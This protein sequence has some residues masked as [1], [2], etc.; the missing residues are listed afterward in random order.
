MKRGFLLKNWVLTGAT[1]FFAGILNGLFGS[2]GG[3]IAVPLFI[4]SGI[5]RK[6][7]H[8]TSLF[9]MFCLSLLSAFL[10]LDKSGGAIEQ[11]VGF[12]PGGILGAAVSA[13]FFKKISPFVLQKIFGGILVFSSA[14]TLWGIV[15]EWIF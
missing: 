8:A 14:K 4:K 6:E 1:G 9:L 13:A 15:S 10:Y 12:L 5:S 7:S 11:A 2:G 3:I